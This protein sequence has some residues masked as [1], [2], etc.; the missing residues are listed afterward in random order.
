MIS[1]GRPVCINSA[2]LRGVEAQPVSVEVSLVQS[3]PGISIVGMA[4]TA[5]MEAK[6]RVRT[7]IRMSGFSMPNKKIVVNLAPS[8][9]KK[10]GCAFDLPIALGVLVATGQVSFEFV[11]GRLFV[12]ELGL[13]GSVRPVPGTL[14]YGICAHKQSLALVSAG[15]ESVPIDTLEQLA[16]TSLID[17][18]EFE[19]LPKV[20][21]VKTAK[22]FF[23][24]DGPDFSDVS[25]HGFAKRAAQ[26]AVTGNHGLLMVGPPGSG[27]TML[28]SRMVTIL[29]PLSSE[30]M[31]DT[32]LVHSVAGED[33]SPILSG[34]R[35][36]RS[37]HHSATMAG[38]VG[39]GNPLKPGEVSLAHNGA[40]FLDELPEFSPKALQSL[41]QPLESAKVCLTRADGNLTFP[42]KFLL[43]A[44]SNPCPCGYLGDE[45]HDCTCTAQQVSRYQGRIG[46]P[47]I[48]RIDLQ[49]DVKRLSPA[50]VLDSGNGTDSMTLREGVMLAREFIKWRENK[51]IVKDAQ[52]LV[53]SKDFSRIGQKMNTQQI[54][55]AC[56]LKKDTREFVIEMAEVNHLSG[57]GLVN[58]LRVARTIADLGQSESVNTNHVAEALGFRIR[59]GIGQG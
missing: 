19:P 26:I 2:V 27:K 51:S 16:C 29:P 45:E 49:I 39:G 31:L 14:A 58:T 34:R 13:D 42:A 3:L 10:R 54:V 41:R 44:A 24:S 7:A 40:L 9:I 50:K 56:D 17:S 8:D 12:G 57:R 20:S 5:V 11:N 37:P 1:M 22:E 30:E 18:L 47:L 48:D 28:A 15:Y 55:D 35:P 32:A 59:D 36:F 43:I 21:F 6:E 52:T 4:D 53:V 25:G 46:G 33:I 23:V 38:L